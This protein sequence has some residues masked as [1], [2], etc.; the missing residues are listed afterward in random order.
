MPKSNNKAEPWER[1][2]REST[3]AYEAFSLY[4]DMGGERSARKVGH[5]LSKSWALISA[6]SSKWNWVERARHYDNLLSREVKENAVK[7]VQKIVKRQM[8]IAGL[9]L[10][11]GVER[12]EKYNEEEIDIGAA[13]KLITEGVK[14]E[15]I[16]IVDNDTGGNH[17]DG[18]LE[19]YEKDHNRIDWASMTDE[20]LESLVNYGDDTHDNK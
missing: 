11:V 7:E 6:W 10:K 3:Q 17:S 16:C 9:M 20:E 15:R 19:Q 5:K 8:Q 2:P 1:Q 12:L 4:R 18:V 14:L 13:V